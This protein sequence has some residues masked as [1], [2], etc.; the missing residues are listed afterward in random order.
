[1]KQNKRE[2]GV[3]ERMREEKDL[4]NE[5]QKKRIMEKYINMRKER[6]SE[7]EKER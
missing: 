3:K 7:I 5:K 6:E 4:Q 2:K 1:L